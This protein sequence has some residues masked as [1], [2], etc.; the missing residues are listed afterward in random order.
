MLYHKFFYSLPKYYSSFFSGIEYPELNNKY[1]RKLRK[2]YN[3]TDTSS[4]NEIDTSSNNDTG[5]SESDNSTNISSDIKNKNVI[6]N[7][8]NSL[9]KQH[10]MN[11]QNN[12]NHKIKNELN[13]PFEELKSDKSE[14]QD[15]LSEAELKNSKLIAQTKD[16]MESLSVTDQKNI[17]SDSNETTHLTS[18]NES[19]IITATM[20]SPEGQTKLSP[21]IDL[22]RAQLVLTQNWIDDPHVSSDTLHNIPINFIRK[23]MINI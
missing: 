19:G 12:H 4:N 18:Y 1:H 16:I 14:M 2:K 15:R 9:F 5:T 23:R 21:Y 11:T 3:N 17:A 6:K 13:I 8:N 7:S 20:R 10:I 22:Q